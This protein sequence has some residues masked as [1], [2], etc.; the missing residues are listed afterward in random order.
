MPTAKVACIT[1]VTQVFELPASPSVIHPV[2][3]I[4]Q[5]ELGALLSL[6]NRAQQLAEQIQEAE[7]SLRAALEAGAEVETGIFHAHLK[8]TERRSVSWKAIVERE[9]GEDYARRVLSAT[10]PDTFTTLVVGA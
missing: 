10:H 8:V 7:V 1:S 9:L 4:T 5:F 3:Q 2:Q 6:R